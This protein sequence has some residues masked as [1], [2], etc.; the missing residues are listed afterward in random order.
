LKT[1]HKQAAL[2]TCILI[3]HFNADPAIDEHFVKLD[4][5]FI[6]I[7]VIAEMEYGYYRVDNHDPKRQ[8]FDA[9]IA[10]DDVKLIVC[11]RQVAR[12]FAGIKRQLREK[13]D[14]IPV[15]DIWIA[16][17][18]IAQNKMLVTRD[19]DFQRVPDL[20]VEMW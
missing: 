6:P 13:G 7:P 15:N 8:M 14:M 1:N 5:L 20:N 3:D 9:F 17:C 4:T 16:A 11:D 18:C 12:Y 2:D 19:T 10:R